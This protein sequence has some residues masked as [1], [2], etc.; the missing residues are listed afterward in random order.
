[1]KRI[2]MGFL[3]LILGAKSVIAA[4]Q[5]EFLNEFDRTLDKAFKSHLFFDSRVKVKIGGQSRYRFEYRD[6][7]NLN[8]RTYEDDAMHM[9]RNRLNFDM[10]YL[11]DSGATPFHF[12]IEGQEAHN[13]AESNVNQTNGFVNYAD[14][15]QLFVE[16]KSPAKKLPLTLKIGRQILSY[17][18]ERFVGGFDW[19]NVARV[20]DAVKVVYNPNP[21]FMLD[22]FASRVVRVEVEKWDTTPHNDNFYGIYAST[23]PFR[24][25]MDQLLDTFLFIRH[26]DD[27]TLAGENGK[28]GELK[29]Y[30]FGNRFKGKKK[31]WD[32]G[33]EYAIQLGSRSHDEIAAWAFH[34]ELG[35]TFGKL[36]W[37]PRIYGEYNHASGDRN[38]TDGK[39]NTFDNLFPT[40][41]NKYGF[42]DFISLKN[43]NDFMLGASVKP[44]A[45]LTF[46]ADFHWFMLDAKESAWFNAGGAPF[47]A[48]NA[49]AD[50]HLGEELDLLAIYK[51]TEHLSVMGGYSLF[52]AGPFAK[53]T[54][55]HDDANFFYVQTILNF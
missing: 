30:T 27:P 2:V 18:D 14:L 24:K 19:S 17:G 1:M 35:Y 39:F 44:H 20:F 41:H 48:A 16:L 31:G 49:N 5:P 46:S 51:L 11:S 21:Q 29:E 33:T 25:H 7:F 23:K 6:D 47:R 52:I 26:N 50:T 32:Y 15:R 37:T 36:P 3:I 10:V 40:N 8:D 43:I 22:L 12:F 4:T 34:Q 13:F 45:R 54:G 9:L 38:P 42:I 53:D 28:R 55:A